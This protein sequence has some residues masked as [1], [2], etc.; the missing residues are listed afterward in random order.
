MLEVLTTFSPF[1]IGAFCV[2]F[3]GYMAQ[4]TILQ[5]LYY[6]SS[7]PSTDCKWKVQSNRKENVGKFWWHPLV[8]SKPNR[9]DHHGLFA[10]V[11]LVVA[12]TCALITAECSLRR[13]NFMMFHELKSNDIVILLL[14]LLLA[15]IWENVAEY[16]WHRMMHLKSFYATFHKYHHFYKS[17]EPWDDMYIHPL[18][19]FGYYCI[20]YGP[21][22]LFP[23]H[24]VAFL[25]YMVIMGI[26]GIMDHSGIK[27]CLPGVYN[28]EDHDNHHMKFEVNYAFPFPYMD[29]LHDTFEGELLGMKFKATKG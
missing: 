26:T 9:G 21:P 24:Y 25:M 4:T 15:V 16:Y 22:F 11:N 7:S 23:I 20:L 29:I 14:Q 6:T 5:Y 3:F 1:S 19:A 13:I 17:P 10:M 18:E 2:I 12:S 27:F 8:S 28:S